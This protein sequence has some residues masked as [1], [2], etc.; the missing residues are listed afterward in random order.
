MPLTAGAV[1]ALAS[2]GS[3]HLRVTAAIS[4]HFVAS[5]RERGLCP[6]SLTS[7]KTV[8]PSFLRYAFG[9]APCRIDADPLR[10]IMRRPFGFA[11][12]GRTPSV[13]SLASL[14]PAAPRELGEQEPRS[15]PSGKS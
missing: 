15:C 5:E 8:S 12:G 1:L 11:S 3:F 9:C 10:R 6:L 4:A 14:S 7:K 13:F 2:D